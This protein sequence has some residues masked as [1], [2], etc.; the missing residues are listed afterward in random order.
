MVAGTSP[1]G[2]GDGKG[3]WNSCEQVVASTARHRVD[4]CPPAEGRPV[5]PRRLGGQDPRARGASGR[6]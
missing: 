4:R 5:R 1:C 2:T 6:P 3:I